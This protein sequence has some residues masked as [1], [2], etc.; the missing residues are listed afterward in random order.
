MQEPPR[1]PA[2]SLV[3]ASDRFQKPD[4]RCREMQRGR[5]GSAGI[6]SMPASVATTSMA[7]NFALTGRA[8]VAMRSVLAKPGKLGNRQ[9]PPGEKR[10]QDRLDLVSAAR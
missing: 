10:R 2:T 1:E 4:R 7:L 3:T 8:S 6:F 5:P 9:W